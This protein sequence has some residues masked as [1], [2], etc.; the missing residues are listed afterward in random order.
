MVLSI[1]LGA[2]VTQKVTFLGAFVA[3]LITFFTPCVLP[4]IPVWLALA[5]GEASAAAPP[6][7]ASAA[8]GLRYRALP[9]TLFF[10]L[11]FSLIFVAVGAAASSLGSFLYDRR[12][13]LR[14][15]GGIVMIAFGLSLIGLKLP[16]SSWLE[17]KRMAISGQNRGF[18]GAFA[19]GLAFAAGW[20]PC[21]GPILGSIL[22]MAAIQSSLALGAKLLCVYS[23]G[24]AL[25]FL[26]AA[27]LWGR[28]LAKLKGLGRFSI[29]LSRALG[30][31]TIAIGLLLVFN[32]ITLL[33][34]NY[35]Y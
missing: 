13:I 35:P 7:A 27:L 1:A 25:P 30:L 18:L 21:V 4:M 31:L 2:I 34:F 33:A 5:T 12:E 8:S 20:T 26:L 22:A 14:L 29:W 32:K 24:L 15:V 11:G 23:L 28:F 6:N 19:V 9:P 10:V 17:G 3:G 16:F